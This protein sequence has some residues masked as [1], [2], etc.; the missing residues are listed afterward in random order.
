MD[1]RTL[2]ILNRMKD[3]RSKKVI[4]ISH[5]LLNENTRYLG[6]ACLPGA[7]GLLLADWTKKGYGLIQLPCPEQKV[8]GG[9]LKPAMWL[10]LESRGKLKA[11][12]MK[13]G[14]PFFVMY[15]RLR[16]AILV[17][18]VVA[19]IQDYQRNGFDVVSLFAVDGSPS[20]GLNKTMNLSKS[21]DLIS[22]SSIY[23][24]NRLGFNRRLFDS[25]SQAG[26]GLFIS[27]IRSKL[28][29]RGIFILFQSFDMQDEIVLETKAEPMFFSFRLN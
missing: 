6:G 8:W 27:A 7:N 5:C 23:N 26:A 10:P 18:A 19:S 15:T 17:D 13:V 29:K 3:S 22:N 2:T 25:C 16:F 4:F 14:F 1:E 11:L 9:L 20:C 28:V 12:F 21:F 24:L